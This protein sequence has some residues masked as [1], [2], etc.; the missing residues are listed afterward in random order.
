LNL[1]Y[2][3]LYL[4]TGKAPTTAAAVIT[5]AATSTANSTIGKAPDIWK[6][7]LVASDKKVEVNVIDRN[8]DTDYAATG[9][10]NI[11]E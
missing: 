11:P 5:E 3:K 1:G 7:T 10:W 6:Y 8:G 2:A 4:K 9:S